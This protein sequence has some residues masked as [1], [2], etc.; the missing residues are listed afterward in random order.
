[1]LNSSKVLFL[2]RDGV[3]NRKLD[4]DYVKTWQEFDFLPGVLDA[5]ALCSQKGY[6]VIVV[7][8]QAGVNKGLMTFRQL[9]EI[10][11]KMKQAVLQNDGH[12]LESYYCPHRDEDACDCRK[13]KA[14]LFHQALD[15]LSIDP[16]RLKELWVVGDSERDI[17]AGQSIGCQAIIVGPEAKRPTRAEYKAVDF[18]DA[19]NQILLK[20]Q[21]I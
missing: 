6:A 9:R 17:I 1:M 10:D 12:I 19:L 3:I 20:S 7:S 13:P 11:L 14:G 15:D 4:Q 2:D 21:P 16:A 8:N 5:L 18:P